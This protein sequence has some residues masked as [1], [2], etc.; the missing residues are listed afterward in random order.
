MLEVKGQPTKT[1]RRLMTSVASLAL[2]FAAFWAPPVLRVGNEI[3]KA[4]CDWFFLNV[5]LRLMQP[6]F[7]AN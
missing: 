6:V 2:A 7:G 5:F 3:I 4:L 1:R